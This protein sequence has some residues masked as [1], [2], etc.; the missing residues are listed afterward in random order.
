MAMT[1][2]VLCRAA[3]KQEG[4]TLPVSLGRAPVPTREKALTEN[5]TEMGDSAQ[6]HPLKSPDLLTRGPPA[7]ERS[8]GLSERNYANQMHGCHLFR[9]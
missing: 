6:T 8:V 1:G 3:P 5:R 2:A 7:L 9:Q 4:R